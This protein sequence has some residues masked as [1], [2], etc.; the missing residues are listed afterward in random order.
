MNSNFIRSILN[1]LTGG[2]LTWIF[3]DLLKCSGDSIG[4]ATCAASFIP[5][6]YKV[7]AGIVF[8][9]V[10]FLLKMFGGSGATVGQNISAPVVP[11]VPAIDAKP[12]VV[13]ASQVN[14]TK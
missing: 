4:T 11:V 1:V 12:G 7:V 5:A 13:T 3:T 8:V 10:G 9:A 2:S 14:S 6:E